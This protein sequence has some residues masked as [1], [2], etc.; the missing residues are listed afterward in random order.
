MMDVPFESLAGCSP[1]SVTLVTEAQ[2]LKA[3]LEFVSSAYVTM[4]G[5]TPALGRLMVAAEDD[6][7]PPS[8]VAILSHRFGMAQFGG[9]PGIVGPGGGDRVEAG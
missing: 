3:S 7:T 2:S 6:R 8:A 4:L 1:W 5:A 9:D